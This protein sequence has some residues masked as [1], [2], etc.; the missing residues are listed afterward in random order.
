MWTVGVLP[1]GVKKVQFDS[2]FGPRI[3]SSWLG[4]LPGTME[5]YT[6]SVK[7]FKWLLRRS[8]R[9]CSDLLRVRELFYRCESAVS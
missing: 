8:V 2:K 9:S 6:M 1:Q 7:Q 5:E 3:K 4:E